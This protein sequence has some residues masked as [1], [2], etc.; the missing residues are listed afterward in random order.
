AGRRAAPPPDPPRRGRPRLPGGHPRCAGSPPDQSRDAALRMGLVP[1]RGRPGPPRRAG[2]ARDRGHVKHARRF[3]YIDP[4]GDRFRSLASMTRSPGNPAIR[5]R[6]VVAR[7]RI[8][9]VEAP[10][11]VPLPHAPKR[12]DRL[13]SRP[14]PR[15]VSEDALPAMSARFEAAPFA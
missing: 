15:E 9:A 1:I 8:E 12:P 7:P 14:G 2:A 6:T 3:F 10:P 11:H 13:L 4:C 5:T